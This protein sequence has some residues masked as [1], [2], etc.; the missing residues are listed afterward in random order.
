MKQLQT[1]MASTRATANFISSMTLRPLEEM[2]GLASTIEQT[3]VPVE[4]VSQTNIKAK[5]ALQMADLALNETER[6]L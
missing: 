6:A 1:S 2:K 3:V 4:V 5:S